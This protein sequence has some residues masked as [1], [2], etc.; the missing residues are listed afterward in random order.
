MEPHSALFLLLSSEGEQLRMRLPSKSGIF[1]Y[2]NSCKDRVA[3]NT[4]Y[5]ALLKVKFD[6]LCLRGHTV[7]IEQITEKHLTEN[8]KGSNA[9]QSALPC[10]SYRF[11][12]VNLVQRSYCV[13]DH[14]TA[15]GPAVRRGGQSSKSTF[16]RKKRKGMRE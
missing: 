4:R 11:D 16:Q 7:N 15:L 5:M 1:Q 3:C 9:Q 12:F 8:E 6:F 14:I 2:S 10:I 13:R